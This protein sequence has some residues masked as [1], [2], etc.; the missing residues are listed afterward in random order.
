MISSQR[1]VCG[2]DVPF[3]PAGPPPLPR[4]PVA[5]RRQLSRGAARIRIE[6]VDQTP[7]APVA[8]VV[9]AGGPPCG[10]PDHG[11]GLYVSGPYR[12]Q[13]SAAFNAELGIDPCPVLRHLGIP[14][15]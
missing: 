1:R 11:G 15:P 2:V 3:R 6:E 10:I 5:A 9:C 8:D 12:R 4:N 13:P 14:V 7:A